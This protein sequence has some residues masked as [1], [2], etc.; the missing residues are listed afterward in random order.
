MNGML[1]QLAK[2]R[3]RQS[4]SLDE[5]EQLLIE[6][7]RLLDSKSVEAYNL[8]IAI[9]CHVADQ[10]Y[11][12]PM[13]NQL[14]H[15]NIS[16]SRI[17]LYDRL[18][19][20]R[21]ESY[22]PES[23]AYDSLLRAFY[24]SKTTGSTLTRPQKEVFDAFQE[25]RRL[26][27]SAP[28]SFGK[29]RIIQE[30]I[31]HNSFRNIAL[32]MPT[33]SLLSE[34]YRDIKDS[35]EGYIV[36]KSSKMKVDDT[37]RYILV[38]TP[39]R[40]TAFRDEN[41]DFHFDFFVMDEIYKVDYK[42][43]DD[44]FRIFSDILLSLASGGSD[45]YLIGPYISDFSKRFRD[46]F[47]VK[48]LKFDVE[49]VQK[50]FYH[51]D[52]IENRGNHSI[53]GVVLKIV[54][55]KFKNLL[56]LTT[57]NKIDGKFL[58]YR[59]QK[60]YVEDT[61]DKFAKQIE[62]I[63]FN[64]DLVNYLSD[65]VSPQWSLIECVKRGV[66]FHHGAMPR[67]IQDLIVDEFNESAAS[68]IDYLF[69]TTSLTEGINTSAKNVILYDQ[70]IGAG[71]AI[72][73]LD[74][75]NIEGRAGRFMKHFVGR[76]FH[77]ENYIENE[78]ECIVEI[79]S[80]DSASPSLEAIIQFED[81][82]LSPEGTRK[83]TAIKEH[84]EQSGIPYALIRSNRYVSVNGQL[85]LLAYLSDSEEAAMFAFDTPLPRVEISR[86]IFSTIYDFL[87]TTNDI[88]RN[89]N[90]EQ[91]KSVLLQ[92]TNFYLYKQ[93][94]FSEMVTHPTVLKGR[95]K[96]DSRIRYVFD[97]IS[98][99]FEFIWPRYLMAFQQL[100]NYTAAKTGLSPISL[101]LMIAQLEYG[102]TKNHEI[103][104]RDCGLPTESIRKISK[105]F[106]NCETTE[107]IQKTKRRLFGRIIQS[108]DPIE[109]KILN[110]YI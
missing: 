49:I 80:L 5:I 6:T 38:L 26:I 30:I 60:R 18:I 28:T 98:K 3:S 101:E 74:R 14:L 84:L 48:I 103:L 75:R 88:G 13:V 110:R 37:K 21:N 97:L 10:N 46:L 31:K 77:L 4:I 76:V 65:T 35:I 54:D 50:D 109:I 91:G 32:I 34:Q 42:L 78:S 95:S 62:E 57:N 41:P 100:Y 29:T 45:F 36:S 69:C 22:A 81:S 17:F 44:R 43:D 92:L 16:K 15:D 72:G 73:T 9:I 71:T 94:S 20:S 66:A 25:N 89:F 86:L 27:V 23:S 99:Y 39:E 108:L 24:T 52:H 63:E 59:Y 96:I 33:V 82:M 107:D 1:E 85:S 83:K 7:Y 58:I 19:K 87:F 12:D 56:R 90:E 68:G 64:T 93:P 8:C 79:E 67:H 105:F 55:N 11:L 70:K 104:L 47:N 53:E 2:I 102:T 61:A 40:M 51:L 106:V